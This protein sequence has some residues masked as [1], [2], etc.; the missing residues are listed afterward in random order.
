MRSLLG[1]RVD[2]N[3]ASPTGRSALMLAAAA[4]HIE[5]VLALLQALA[6]ID[7][8]THGNQTAL[9]MAAC[10]GHEQ[11]ISTLL[12][13]RAGVNRADNI[14]GCTPL[15]LAAGHE[16]GARSDRGGALA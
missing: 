15:L 13:A 10:G 12:L 6:S 1:R 11:V 5:V 14:G 4:G 7:A 16:D 8:A 9:M 3:A 2:P